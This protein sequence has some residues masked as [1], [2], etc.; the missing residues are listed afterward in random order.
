MSDSGSII[1]ELQNEDSNLHLLALQRSLYSVEKKIMAVQLA[2]ALLTAISGSIIQYLQPLVQSYV[3]IICAAIAL[4]DAFFL[5]SLKGK[6]QT[7]AAKI[8]ELFDTNVLR[9]TWNTI[10]VGDKPKAEELIEIPQINMDQLRNW[11]SESIN[12]LPISVARIL[13][14]RENCHYDAE[15]RNHYK[16]CIIAMSTALAL[17]IVTI[18][19]L[20]NRPF[21]DSLA[22]LVAPCI[23]MFVLMIRETR[24]QSKAIERRDRLKSQI[25]EIWNSMVSRKIDEAELETWSRHLQDEI[26]LS[27]SQDSVLFDWFYNLMRNKME[28]RIQKTTKMLATEYNTSAQIKN[29]TN[30]YSK[31]NSD[32]SNN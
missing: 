12:D 32:K 1:L 11:Y 10:K 19:V 14:Q 7:S 13:C 26:F 6:K 15:V 30:S 24:N 4:L 28:S 9:M 17:V 16:F 3:T 29:E 18:G 5:E 25:D 20:M 8:Q 31:E 21:V 2:I 22:M 23:P 27:R